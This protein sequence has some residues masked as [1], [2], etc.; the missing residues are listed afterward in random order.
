MAAESSNALA[1]MSLAYY[2]QGLIYSPRQH[3]VP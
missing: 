2:S 1:N 3:S